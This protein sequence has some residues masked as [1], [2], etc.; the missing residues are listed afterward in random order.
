M[1][2]SLFVFDTWFFGFLSALT[3]HYIHIHST[4]PTTELWKGSKARDQYPHLSSISVGCQRNPLLSAFHM[5]R[6]HILIFQCTE[7]SSTIPTFTSLNINKHHYSS[8]FHFLQCCST[9]KS[10]RVLQIQF[11]STIFRSID[12]FFHS[13]SQL[14]F[15]FY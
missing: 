8:F 6:I 11:C 1:A 10:K 2:N 14:S 7:I 4:T 13:F 3:Q 15:P 5:L 9:N 12:S